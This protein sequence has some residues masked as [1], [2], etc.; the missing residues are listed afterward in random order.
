VR[1][2]DEGG[3]H[4]LFVLDEDT[5]ITGFNDL[6]VDAHGWVVVG[7][8]RFRPSRGEAPNAGRL[9]VVGSSFVAV[10]VDEGLLWPNGI[11]F[12]PDGRRAYVCDFA[13]G[14]VLRCAVDRQGALAESVEPFAR[15]GGP[16]EADG[17]AVDAEGGVWVAT[18]AA[19]GLV[20][21]DAEGDVSARVDGIAPFVSSIALGGPDG[22]DVLV[23]TGGGSE[24]G[25]VLR[26]RAE[27]AGVPL[28]AATI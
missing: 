24:G 10:A 19:G 4:E 9:V 14:E 2:D 25:T 3:V 27:V 21:L 15:A 17:L 28:P 26:G 12:S 18:G 13:T 20:R 16:H 7:A 8:L 22:R 1:I 11:G 5:G 6:A 23:T